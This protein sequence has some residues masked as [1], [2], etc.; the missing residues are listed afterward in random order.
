MNNIKFRNKAKCKLCGDII[1]SKHRHDF[2]MCR[3]EAIFIDGGNE[4]W[5]A[6]GMLEHFERLYE[7]LKPKLMN[8]DEWEVGEGWH[9]LITALIEDLLKLGWDG[10]LQQ[11]KSKF[12]GLRFY[13]GSGNDAIHDR[14]EQAESESIKTCEYCGKPGK[15]QGHGWIRTVCDEH[16]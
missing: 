6:G 4:Y 5:R 2:V 11:V 12:G 3:C 8:K 15:R 14:I 10:D 13:I 1:E 16:A 7:P 9:P